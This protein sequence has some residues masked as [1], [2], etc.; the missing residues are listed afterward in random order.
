MNKLKN[1]PT[2][3]RFG[4]LLVIK[5]VE[6]TNDGKSQFLCSCD[7]GNK[8]VIPR[9]SFEHNGVKSCG[10][11]LSEKSKERTTKHGLRFTRLYRIWSGMKSRCCNPNNQHHKNYGARGITVCDEWRNDFKAFYDWAM[12]N[13][14]SDELTIDRIDNDGNYEPSNCRW[15]TYSE[16]NKNRR[17]KSK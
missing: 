4:R 1:D 3:K 17:R 14:Y 12:N 9:H 10:C 5:R 2:G 16:Q 15:A 11:L 8:K 7:C 13:G 6:N